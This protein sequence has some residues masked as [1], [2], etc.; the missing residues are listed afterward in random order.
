MAAGA[1]WGRTTRPTTREN[2]VNRSAREKF[3][4]LAWNA[5]TKAE[6]LAQEATRHARDGERN[7]AEPLAAASA[8]WTD[9][10]RTYTA[11]TA[12]LPEL[13]TTGTES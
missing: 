11:I 6:D 13:P 5:V 8:L 7:R 1:R 4:Q 9:V 10:A 3:I 2:P 12:V